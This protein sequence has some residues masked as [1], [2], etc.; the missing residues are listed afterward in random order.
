MREE[1]CIGLV[2]AR[3][4]SKGLLRKNVTNL[5]GKPL[6]AWTIQAALRSGRLS[7]VVL[8]TEDCS[9]AD[10]GARYG[11]E[12]P[13]LRPKELASDEAGH[14]E[15]VLHLL[16]WLSKNMGLCPT[17]VMLLQPTSPLRKTSDIN[18]AVEIASSRRAD[19][20]VSVCETHCHP[21]LIKSLRKDGT[22]ASFMENAP[23]S[24]SRSIRRQDLPPAYFVNGAI[25]L[26]KTEVLL[27][28]KT[29]FPERT[30]PYVM[31][32]ARS[33][34]IDSQ[35]DRDLV[36]MIMLNERECKQTQAEQITDRSEG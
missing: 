16:K 25:Y 19:S 30:Y 35:W 27:N 28:K 11:A 31:P 23:D 21:Y 6:I 17:Y 13:F 24:G 18:E 9:I 12:V 4:G 22:L 36:E 3:A 20:V 34:Q 10:T 8:S 15:V 7:R 14:M 33:Y 1:H 5:A 29:F 32:A 26:T 2:T